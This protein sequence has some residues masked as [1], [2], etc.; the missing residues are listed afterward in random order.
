M[1]VY[2]VT[3]CSQW[4]GL[5][6]PALYVSRFLSLSHMFTPPRAI[7]RSL[8]VLLHSVYSLFFL[9]IKIKF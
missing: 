4:I 5:S 8:L 6:L 7:S 9:A 2:Y 1:H 3:V